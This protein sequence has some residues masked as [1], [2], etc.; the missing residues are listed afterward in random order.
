MPEFSLLNCRMRF[1]RF[2]RATLIG[3]GIAGLC[4]ISYAVGFSAQ[5]GVAPSRVLQ[6][7]ASGLLGARAFEGAT[8]IAALGLALH[9]A[10]ALT[11]AAFFCAMSNRFP[12]LTRRAALW[13]AIYGFLIF[14]LMNLVVLPLS[15]FPRKVSFDPLVVSTGLLVHTLLIGVPIALAAR[16]ATLPEIN[17]PLR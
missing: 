17:A 9:F 4:D 13:G 7:V 3:G 14:W 10:I 12:A 2:A 5:R 16:K 6:S 11:F 1:T 8:P 15:A